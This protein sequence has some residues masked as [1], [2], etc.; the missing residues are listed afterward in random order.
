MTEQDQIQK[1]IEL[2]IDSMESS[3][4]DKVKIAFHANAKVVGYLHGDFM[5]LSTEEF[6]G[7]VA[8]Q[9]PSPKEKSEN[10]IFDILSC[11]IEGTIASVK[12]RDQYL[13]ITFLDILS[14]IKQEG[15][16]KIYNKLFYV[17]SE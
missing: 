13:G 7:F 16:W 12:I 1:V 17:E 10:I 5:E 11:D 3:D 2:Y 8:A 4:P 9:K 15:E 6:A 14:L